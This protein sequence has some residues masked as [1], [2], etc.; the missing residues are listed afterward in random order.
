MKM[1]KKIAIVSRTLGLLV[2]LMCCGR[3]ATPSWALPEAA[4]TAL[5][6]QY[7]WGLTNET[8]RQIHSSIIDKVPWRSHAGTTGHRDLWGHSD[9]WFYE[10]KLA[11]EKVLQDIRR[12]NPSFSEKEVQKIYREATSITGQQRIAV[13]LRKACPILSQKEAMA[14]A[15]QTHAAHL[16][17]DS[18]TATGKNLINVERAMSAVASPSLDAVRAENKMNTTKALNDGIPFDRFVGQKPNFERLKVEQIMTERNAKAYNFADRSLIGLEINGQKYIYTGDTFRARN[19]LRRFGNS[20]NKV[21]LPDDEYQKFIRNKSNAGLVNKVV[22]E[23]QITGKANTLKDSQTQLAQKIAEV[24]AK[25]AT[26]QKSLTDAVWEKIKLAAPYAVGGALMSVGENWDVLDA[27]Y[28]GEEEWEKA[29]K[30]TGLDF[31]GYTV[32]PIIVDSV[33]A[34]VGEKVALVTSL[35]NAG[36]GYTISYF[37]WGAG[38]EYISYQTGDIAYDELIERIHQRG[39]GAVKQTMMVP[40]NA[41]VLKIVGGGLTGTV[42]VPIVIIG[43]GYTLQRV[44]DWYQN[45]MWEQTIYVDDVVAIL[46]PDLVEAFTLASPER[47]VSLTEPERRNSLTDPDEFY[48][49]A[50][51]ESH[52]NIFGTECY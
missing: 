27:A 26:A 25:L 42:I 4:H 2:F 12:A 48:N 47:R 43:G 44:G 52:A 11:K 19:A 51:P 31:A 5:A 6:N 49:L 3:A 10:G 36:M 17:G 40:V 34:K 24:K 46:G 18:T 38:K 22:P 33:L 45:K 7:I 39:I 20:S 50:T 9:A 35:K 30:R 29:L 16:I 32:T 23:S 1:L 8:S 15:E 37:I 14:L 13:E 41:L 21:I 28:N